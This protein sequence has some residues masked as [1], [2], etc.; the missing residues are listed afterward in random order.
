MTEEVSRKVRDRSEFSRPQLQ[1]RADEDTFVSNHHRAPRAV[2][3]RGEQIFGQERGHTR[4]RPRGGA[5]NCSQKYS[6]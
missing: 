4:R 2:V 5:D 1:R 3:R 6:K